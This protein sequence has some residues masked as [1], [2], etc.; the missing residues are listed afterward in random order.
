MVL[1]VL[2]LLSPAFPLSAAHLSFHS[3]DQPLRKNDRAISTFFVAC[4]CLLVRRE[5][6]SP[7]SDPSCGDRT[8]RAF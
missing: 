1:R 7:S 8:R 4:P 6:S 3:T 2:W 5:S